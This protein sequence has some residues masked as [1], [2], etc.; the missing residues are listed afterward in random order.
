MRNVRCVA[1]IAGAAVL[2]A[3]ATVVITASSMRSTASM[4]LEEAMRLAGQTLTAEQ[5]HLVA[6]A[7]HEQTAAGVRLLLTLAA[8][9]GPAG[10]EA[11]NALVNLRVMLRR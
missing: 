2:T 9:H 10:E 8:E 3:T 11:R 1:E 4:T 5:R 6:R 7:A